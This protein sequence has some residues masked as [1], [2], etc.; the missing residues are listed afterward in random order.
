MQ[1]FHTLS[2][3]LSQAMDWFPLVFLF[4]NTKV[5]ELREDKNSQ[6]NLKPAKATA[7]SPKINTKTELNIGP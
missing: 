6:Q 4:Y 3:T 7:V 2:A 5:S 1:R